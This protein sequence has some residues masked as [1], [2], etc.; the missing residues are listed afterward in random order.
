M[1]GFVLT[2]KFY[3]GALVLKAVHLFYT[4]A[5]RRGGRDCFRFVL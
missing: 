5:L 1:V 4:R 2:V 3:D